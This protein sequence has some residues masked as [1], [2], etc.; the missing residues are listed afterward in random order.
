MI[1]PAKLVEIPHIMSLTRACARHMTEMG[2]QQWNDLYPSEEAF[3]KDQGRGELF[4]LEVSGLVV[5]CITVSSLMDE[6]YKSV[7][8][9]TPNTKNTYIHRLAVHPEQQGKGLARRLM[10]WAEEKA[11]FEDRLSIRLDTFS[12]NKRN[13]RFYEAR[14]YQK[15]GPVY[16]PKQSPYPFYCYELLL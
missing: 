16:F 2:I 10:D 15:L 3:L 14:G 9:L 8:W 5:G 4:V 6:E 7:E 13:Q 11:A 12:R 1:R